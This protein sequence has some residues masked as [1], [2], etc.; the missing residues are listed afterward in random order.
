MNYYNNMNKGDSISQYCKWIGIFFLSLI[1]GALNIGAIGSLLKLLA[2]VPIAIWLMRNHR[3]TRNKLMINTIPFVSIC[4]L[5]CLW[6]I[7]SV[8]SIDRA[9][10]QVMFFILIVSVCGYTFNEREIQYLKRCLIW[11]SRISAIV[12][13]LSADYLMGRIYLN[14]FVQEDPNYL[15]AYFLFAIVYNTTRLLMKGTEGRQKFIAALELVIYLYIVLATGS[16]G[17][18]FAIIVAV[19]VVILFFQE[20]GQRVMSLFSKRV[21]FVILIFVSYYFAN[22]FI[23]EDIMA[24]FTLS[25]ISESNGTGRYELWQDAINAFR[26]SSFSRKLIGYGTATIKDVTYLFAFH[27]HNVLHNIYLENLIEIGLIGLVAYVIHIFAFVK[28]AIISKDMFSI[29]ILIGMIVLSFSTSLYAFKPF[30]NILIFIFC[31]S[32][33]KSRYSQ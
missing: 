6:S 11:A 24:R 18:L 20:E 32:L 15:C 3:I 13:L 19:S 5:S 16:R 8:A 28:A 22:R 1:V 29:A 9:I 21:L 33:S 17:G 27:R 2:I 10:T 26:D 7:N 30:W 25:A 4:F 23:S 31:C 14:S 12:V